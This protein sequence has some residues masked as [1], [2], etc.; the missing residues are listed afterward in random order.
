MFFQVKKRLVNF[1]VTL[2]FGEKVIF[3]Q[4]KKRFMNFLGGFYGYG[5]NPC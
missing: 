3:F 2:V 1:V 5:G 4:V